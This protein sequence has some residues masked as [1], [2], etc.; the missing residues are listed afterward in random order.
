MCGRRFSGQ[1]LRRGEIDLGDEMLEILKFAFSSFEVWLGFI[2]ILMM[3][4]AFANNCLTTVFRCWNRFVRHLNVRKAG[5]PPNHLDADGDF[6]PEP[7]AED[8]ESDDEQ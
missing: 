1:G 3:V 7:I 4:F 2:I 8:E 5:W 6:K